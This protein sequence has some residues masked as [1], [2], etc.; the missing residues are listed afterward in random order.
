MSPPP[1]VL[2]QR[3]DGSLRTVAE[4]EQDVLHNAIIHFRGNVSKACRAVGVGRS[5]MYRK[6]NIKQEVRPR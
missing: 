6:L 2:L 5:S 3:P 4:V 1:V